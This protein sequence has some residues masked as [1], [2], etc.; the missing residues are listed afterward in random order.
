MERLDNLVSYVRKRKH[1]NALIKK[2]IV[3]LKFYNIS[4]RLSK[5]FSNN[6]PELMNLLNI[7]E[8]QNFRTLSYWSLR[9]TGTI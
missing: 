8:I 7:K 6:H 4:Y 3:N 1:L 9:L 5:Y 2:I